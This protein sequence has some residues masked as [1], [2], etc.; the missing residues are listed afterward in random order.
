MQRIVQKGKS[1]T[2]KLED[3]STF[4]YSLN[5]HIFTYGV[6]DEIIGSE[7]TD[8]KKHN[9]CFEELEMQQAI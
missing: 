7:H 5:K 3:A 1:E 8:F 4:M 9:S 2:S 6:P